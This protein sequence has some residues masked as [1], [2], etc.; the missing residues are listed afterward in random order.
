M[1]LRIQREAQTNSDSFNA[2]MQ[3]AVHQNERLEHMESR[4]LNAHPQFPETERLEYME[5]LFEAHPQFPVKEE[6]VC[7]KSRESAQFRYKAVIAKTTELGNRAVSTKFP[8]RVMNLASSWENFMDISL[9]PPTPLS[10]FNASFNSMIKIFESISAC[11]NISTLQEMEDDENPFEVHDEFGMDIT[12]LHS[13]HEPKP[14]SKRQRMRRTIS[15]MYLSHFKDTRD[16][17]PQSNTELPTKHR[18]GVSMDSHLL[19]AS[20]FDLDNYPLSNIDL[21]Q[22]DGNMDTELFARRHLQNVTPWSLQPAKFI[23]NVLNEMGVSDFQLESA[24]RLRITSRKSKDLNILTDIVLDNEWLVGYS[25][26]HMV[27]ILVQTCDGWILNHR[28]G[29]NFVQISVSYC[30]LY[31]LVLHSR[32]IEGINCWHSPSVYK[33][34]TITHEVLQSMAECQLDEVQA[35]LKNKRDRRIKRYRDS[36]LKPHSDDE[37]QP[38]MFITAL[39]MYDSYKNILDTVKKTLEAT[40]YQNVLEPGQD[41]VKNIYARIEDFLMYYTSISSTTTVMGFMSATMLYVR[42]LG[43]NRSIT[44]EMFDLLAKT[45]LDCD[46]ETMMSQADTIGEAISGAEWCLKSW[47]DIRGSKFM[48]KLMSFISTMFVCEFFPLRWLEEAAEE[49]EVVEGVATTNLKSSPVF[50]GMKGADL[51][52]KKK[53]ESV[54]LFGIKLMSFKLVDVNQ[55]T[56][57]LAEALME[58]FLY[59]VKKGYHVFQTGDFASLLYDEDTLLDID[60]KYVN[61][62]SCFQ[63]AYTDTF[64]EASEDLPYTN[65]PEFMVDL[66]VVIEA[67]NTAVKNES[68]LKTKDKRMYDTLMGKLMNCSKMKTQLLTNIKT[69]CVKE[70]PYGI[71][72]TGASGIG[73]SYIT[74]HMYKTICSANGIPCSDQY[75]ANEADGDKFDS[76]TQNVHTVLVIDDLCNQKV[77][78]FTESP[79]MRIIKILNNV[80]CAALKADAIEKGKVWYNYKVVIVTSNVPDLKAATFSNEPVSILRRFEMIIEGKLKQEF[81]NVQGILDVSK[82]KPGELPD[83]WLFTLTKAVVVPKV[84]GDTKT[85]VMRVIHKDISLE[86]LLDI[87]EAD[88]VRHFQVQKNMVQNVKTMINDDYCKHHRP[89][90]MCKKCKREHKVESE[91]ESFMQC[92]TIN[93]EEI[94]RFFDAIEKQATIKEELPEPKKNESIFRR[95]IPLVK[96]PLESQGLSDVLLK[97]SKSLKTEEE[98][99]LTD[100]VTNAQFPAPSKLYASR[101][102]FPDL[103]PEKDDLWNNTVIDWEKPKEDI[104]EQNIQDIVSDW[105]SAYAYYQEPAK[106]TLSSF[107]SIDWD[108]V[109]KAAIVV[110]G[111]TVSISMLTQ[112]L[113]VFKIFKGFNSL[114]Q[115][116]NVAAER[117]AQTAIVPTPI[118]SDSSGIIPTKTSYETTK[119]PPVLTP[120]VVA[121]HPLITTNKTANFHDQ[122]HTRQ[123]VIYHGSPTKPIKCS[124]HI[125]YLGR[126]AW[127]C[128]RHALYEDDKFKINVQ[129]IVH[130]PPHMSSSHYSRTMLSENSVCTYTGDLVIVHLPSCGDGKNMLPLIATHPP[131]KINGGYLCPIA[132]MGKKPDGGN[133]VMW[134]DGVEVRECREPKADFNNVISSCDTL[135]TIR[136]EKQNYK[137][138]AY[139]LKS[140]SEIGDCG[141]PVIFNHAIV[142]VHLSGISEK[143]EMGLAACQSINAREITAILDAH[144]LFKSFI[145]AESSDMPSSI[146]NIPIPL[147]A[148][149]PERHCTRHMNDRQSVLILGAHQSGGVTFRSNVRTY[150][151]IKDIEQCLGV[152][153]MYFPPTHDYLKSEGISTASTWRNDLL[154]ITCTRP[155]FDPSLMNMATLDYATQLSDMWSTVSSDLRS[156]TLPYS[157]DVAVNGSDGVGGITRIDVSTSAGFPL[158]KSKRS[159]WTIGESLQHANCRY[160]LPDYMLT[161]IKAMDE[162][163]AKGLRCN[164]IFKSTFKDEPVKVGKGKMRVFAA[165]DVS[166]TIIVRRYFLPL[167]RVMYYKWKECEMAIGINAHGPEWDEL[168]NYLTPFGTK[169]M[170]AGDYKN[171]D[172][173]MSA[174]VM[175]R[176]FE[177]FIHLAELAGYDQRSIQ[178]M[179]SIATEICFPIYEYDGA[180]IKVMGSNPSGHPL[181]AVLNCVVNSLL[182]RY[183]YFAIYPTGERFNNNVKLIVYGDDGAAGVR[184]EMEQFN[185]QNIQRVLKSCDIVWTDSKKNLVCPPGFSEICEIDFLK[186]SF[187]YHEG[188]NR[189]VGPLAV[190]SLSKMLTTYSSKDKSEDTQFAVLSQSLSG[191]IRESFLHGHDFYTQAIGGIRQLL[192]LHPRLSCELITWDDMCLIFDTFAARTYNKSFCATQEQDLGDLQPQVFY[193]AECKV[194][195]NSYDFRKHTNGLDLPERYDHIRSQESPFCDMIPKKLLMG[196]N[197]GVDLLCFTQE[198]TKE[199]SREAQL[200]GDRECLIY[201]LTRQMEETTAFTDSAATSNTIPSAMDST[202][203][204]AQDT[205][206]LNDFFARPIEIARYQWSPTTAFTEGFDPWTAFITSKRIINKLNNFKLLQGKLHVKFVINGTKFHFG[207]ILA[208]YNPLFSSWNGINAASTLQPDLS[209]LMRATQH[210]CVYLNP[211]NSQGSELVLPF[212]WPKNAVDTTISDWSYLGYIGMTD[213]VPLRSLSANSSIAT[214]VIYAW[215]EDCTISV[216][217]HL[218]AAGLSPQAEDEYTEGIISKPATAIANLAGM[219]KEAPIIGKYA[220]ATEMAAGTMAALAKSMGYSRPA[221]IQ[222]PQV[223][224]Q[225]PVGQ[226]ATTNSEDTSLKLTMDTKQEITLDPTTV[227]LSESD[228]LHIASFC[229]RSALISKFV[230]S[231][232]DSSGQRLF[233]VNNTPK[234]F[235]SQPSDTS[236]VTQTTPSGYLSGLFKYWR[237]TSCYTVVVASSGFHAGR[238]R[239]VFDPAV[240]PSVMEGFNQNVLYSWVIDLQD[241]P[242]ATVECAWGADTSYLKVHATRGRSMYEINQTPVYPTSVS[243]D[244]HNGQM[245]IYVETPLMTPDI[246]IANEVTVLV[247]HHMK[248]CEFAR[249][250]NDGLEFWTPLSSQFGT[251]EP[252]SDE[253]ETTDVNHTQHAFAKAP[254]LDDPTNL[255]FFGERIANLRQLLKRY[256]LN[257]RYQPTNDSQQFLWMNRMSMPRYLGTIGD[258]ANSY[259]L[260]SPINWLTPCFA[261]WRGSI[262]WKVVQSDTSVSLLNTILVHL[263]DSQYCDIYIPYDGIFGQTALV[264]STVGASGQALTTKTTNNSIEFE[265]PFYSNSRFAA[266]RDLD[267]Y[268][269]ATNREIQPRILRDAPSWFAVKTT[270]PVTNK[271]YFDFFCAT[272]EDFN[273]FFFIS[274][275][276]LYSRAEF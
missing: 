109:G 223:F 48:E 160:E 60:K 208:F 130:F 118:I 177:M 7:W 140:G 100:Y 225:V 95:W 240:A 194:F 227:G 215:M 273:L 69:S 158:N 198:S 125:M 8:I 46:E 62:T 276:L 90:S 43:Y 101:V 27:G 3:E 33:R 123:A 92:P 98:H 269:S 221:M 110:A 200:L 268:S 78:Y 88:S 167:L 66:E 216:P 81:R 26:P 148:V 129:M 266:A 82:F 6:V 210:P 16:L 152:K 267:T 230:W 17:V 213:I 178:V 70:K 199:K 2:S 38:Q 37:L 150:Q 116:S 157:W 233:S 220:R 56:S 270:V 170:I 111:V 45:F 190:S 143:K 102:E 21:L 246:T 108:T 203:M 77:E 104:I 156:Q 196:S 22:F 165:C 131:T 228:P 205:L 86:C 19:T 154:S 231:E 49:T 235:T 44:L 218:N 186:R 263:S 73:K 113:R 229:E 103:I 254:K 58:S 201:E 164:T 180:F 168:Y 226:M 99:D 232:T 51:K 4:S 245:A 127:L 251:L 248:D 206:M 105:Q 169:T 249:P 247:Y 91:M 53:V 55:H 72:L 141:K 163:F 219:M 222:Q 183:A 25:G 237:G 239:V 191:Y 253:V 204:A 250:I 39:N 241:S 274:T 173:G 161:H 74:P 47:K 149:I 23:H 135:R 265:V 211:T 65:I 107:V 146:Y 89:Q 42:T 11:S 134:F 75:V 132:T 236:I 257:Q 71:L 80:P 162:C 209:T 61:L 234:Q 259:S 260:P 224:K 166:F 24:A 262:R 9:V 184:P 64:Q 133:T 195:R 128:P 238:L 34:Y 179:R 144:P 76:N 153:Q 124:V 119:P 275:P 31:R 87:L 121:P 20:E 85:F 114:Q 193:Y 181:T 59:L 79:L 271:G 36:Q 252:Q 50:A 63:A 256:T 272:G 197:S 261:G 187:V 112:A 30:Q 117:P 171:Y 28:M 29:W 244:H 176:G 52:D 185:Y 57:D 242:E 145:V 243:S 182:M 40:S 151:M 147:D 84:D 97:V 139:T 192:I 217:T 5:S 106:Q 35:T 138:W 159:I 13:L 155:I 207:R 214:I 54:R 258:E 1:I 32:R 122:V 175:L 255:V 93:T 15:Q 189:V 14:Y 18:R 212:M 83:A 137:G 10:S 174:E 115:Q 264:T 188:L 126:S 136:T 12:V 94:D 96:R 172:K 41:P 68:R 202:F 142:G 67:L 120:L